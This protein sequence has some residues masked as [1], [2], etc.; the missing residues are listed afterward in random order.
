MREDEI[1]L[2]DY[3]RVIWKRRILIIVVT[4]VCIVVGVVK[5]LMLPVKYHSDAVLK[6][7]KKVEAQLTSTSTHYLLVNLASVVELSKSIPVEY[8]R[9]KKGL[10][11]DAEVINGTSMIKMTVNGPGSR[12]EKILKELVNRVIADHH[13][14][15]GNYV[16]FYKTLIERQE[17]DIVEISKE[18]EQGEL[19]LEIMGIDD[20]VNMSMRE[21]SQSNLMMKKLLS[22]R[23]LKEDY[24]DLRDSQYEAHQYQTAIISLEE[25]K[26]KLI[27]E[28]EST[29]I[30][31]KKTRNIMLAGAV[32]LMISLFLVFLIA[33][34][35]NIRKREKEK[36]ESL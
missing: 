34:L 25:N 15:T 30:K 1:E 24:R 20:E 26:T 12:T 16:R 27:G 35:G 11:L 22:Q 4:L 19:A 21:S 29:V 2:I 9:G 32:G 36:V 3:F 5:S 23:S 7:G 14:I 13:K 31:P 28:V 10:D 17:R 6:I 8:G 33:C 18:I